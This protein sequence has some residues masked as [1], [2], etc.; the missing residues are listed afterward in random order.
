[1]RLDRLK[2]LWFNGLAHKQYIQR[3]EHFFKNGL[4]PYFLH[5]SRCFSTSL[6]EFGGFSEI[7]SALNDGG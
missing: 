3:K 7:K 4:G 5:F 6:N 1:M 2:P